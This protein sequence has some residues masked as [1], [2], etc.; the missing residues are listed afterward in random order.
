MSHSKTFLLEIHCEEIPARFLESLSVDF[1]NQISLLIEN[2]FH[3][4]LPIETFYSP[5]K[6]AWRIKN[7]PTT[8]SDRVD[9]QIGPP[10]NLC[11]DQYN[12]PTQIYIKFAEKCDVKIEQINFVK[13]NNKQDL[14][15]SVKIKHEGKATEILLQEAIPNLIRNLHVPKA[16]RWGNSKFQFVRPI[17]N[18]LCLLDDNV[19]PMQLDGVKATNKTWGHRL[20]HIDN[21]NM[22]TINQPEEYESIL[23]KGKIVVSYSRRRSVLEKQLYERAKEVNGCP[24][25][26]QVLLD[27]ISNIIEW[28]KIILGS[29]PESFL[30]LPKEVL[31]TSLAQHQKAFCIENKQKKLIPYFL[32]AANFI[33][34]Q[35]DLIISGNE[36]V[37]KARLY[38]AQFFLKEDRKYPLQDRLGKLEQLTF[39]QELG[40]Y[41]DKTK[42]IVTIATNLANHLNIDTQAVNKAARL[43]KCDL[44]TSMVNEFPELQG[45]IGGEYL[46]QEGVEEAIYIAIK[47]HYRPI[48]SEDDI[49][50]TDIGSILAIADK[51]DTIT[52]CFAIGLIPTGSKD[53]LALRRAAQGIIKIIFKNNWHVNLLSLINLCLREIANKAIKPEQEIHNM[54]SNFFKERIIY[55]LECMNYTQN[56]RRSAIAAGW[57]DLVD[58]KSRCESLSHFIIN[59]T[60]FQRLVNSAKRI[61]NILKGEKYEILLDYNKLEQPE[62]R[63]LAKYLNNID[64]D[65]DMNYDKLLVNLAE[66]ILPLEEFFKS[67]LVKCENTELRSARLT[68]L[69]KIRTNFLKIADFSLWQ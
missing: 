51:L 50:D 41:F 40:T 52:G 49:P 21:P 6:L 67:I 31:I 54:L 18:I 65:I 24:I 14:Y 39:Q 61:N 38:D 63:I 45:I 7:L 11:F 1:K 43:C 59:S 9:V 20:F 42:R 46:K 69:N 37:L 55:Q 36:W 2:N 53:P 10:K 3:V 15:A 44:T 47:E 34:N 56:L 60:D 30:D 23:E 27:T 62:E 25:I 12:A 13:R 68:L 35:D 19:I 64:I 32:T 33:S 8:Q 26:D 28:P 17:R 57:T 48:S 5:R 66:L 29:F 58:L 22:L 4:N 16:M